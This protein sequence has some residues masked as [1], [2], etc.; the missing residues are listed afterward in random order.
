M[1]SQNALLHFDTKEEY[2][3]INITEDLKEFVLGSGIRNGLL[4]IQSLHT[5][6]AIVVNEDE[7]LLLED[8]KAHLESLS[9]KSRRYN[10]DNFDIRTV[11]MCD[12]ECA[13]GHSHCKA[14]G[15][16]TST[17]LNVIGGKLKLGMWQQVFLLEL[18]RA[19]RRS[20]EMHLI[21]E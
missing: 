20:V 16:P 21:G 7:P 3:F 1:R 6:A 4:N 19:R 14:L 2:D 12:G 8:M 10:H 17:T 9:P 11:N 5:T 18:D 15:L 13:N